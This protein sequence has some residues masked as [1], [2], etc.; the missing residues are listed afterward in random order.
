V[1]L[2]A[3]QS[4][5]GLFGLGHIADLVELHEKYHAQL[6][7]KNVRMY[8]ARQAAKP[9]SAANHIRKSL[10]QICDGNMPA[11]DF[12]MI[13]NGITIS[14]P[15]AGLPTD[16]SIVLEPGYDGVY[17]LNGC[18]TIYTAWKFFKDRLAKKPDTG[19]LTNWESIK[20]PLRIVVTQKD[21]RVRTIT[22][23]AN[24]QSEIRPSAFWSHDLVQLDLDRRFERQHIFYERQEGAWDEI[25]RSDPARA[26]EFTSGYINIEFLARVIAAAD[27]TVSLDFAKSP[28]RIFDEETAYCRVFKEKNLRSVR[29]LIFLVNAYEATRMVLR[30]L[31]NEVKKLEDLRPSRFIFPVF[32]LLVHWIAKKARDRVGDFADAVLNASPKSEIRKQV[33]VWLSCHHSGIQQ[34]LSQVWLDTDGWAELDATDKERINEAFHL[35]KL[36]NANLFEDWEE[37]DDNE[38]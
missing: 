12:A 37:F 29:L 38:E 32:R 15:R 4:E 6:F 26:E 21:E 10:E 36:D 33:H 8:L 1:C 19:W 7:A 3:T 31:S 13:H 23:G 16:D 28:N 24:R 22:I 2:E 35:L 27:R 34:V 17:V 18:Q 20:V 5:R 11:G 14:A 9:K 30:D 25:Y